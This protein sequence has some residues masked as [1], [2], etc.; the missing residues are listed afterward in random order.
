MEE[1]SLL[2]SCDCGCS[3]LRFTKYDD[4]IIIDHYETSFY[5]HQRPIRSAIK[6]YFKRLWKA[7]VG[8]DFYLYDIVLNPDEAKKFYKDLQEFFEDNEKFL[9]KNRVKESEQ[10][11]QEFRIRS[12][13]NV[14]ES[15]KIIKTYKQIRDNVDHYFKIYYPGGFH[16][17]DIDN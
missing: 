9:L 6:N 14:S 10:L 2:V 12:W 17:D 4:G 16:M 3:I 7:L 8:K 5:S 11:L 1:K 13:I 15:D